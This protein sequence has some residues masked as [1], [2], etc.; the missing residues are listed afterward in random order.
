MI[1]IAD[2]GS[3]KTSWKLLTGGETQSFF[4]QGINPYFQR[5]DEI[6]ESFQKEV[7][8]LAVY[9]NS[10]QQF[11]FYG[12]GCGNEN[13]R[14]ILKKI[15]AEYFPNADVEINTDLLGAARGACRQSEAIAGILGTGSNSCVYNGSNVVYSLPSLGYI[16]GDEGS[17][18]FLG[19]KLIQAYLSKELTQENEAKFN[20]KYQLTKESILESVYKKSFP[21]RYL[22]SFAK[23]L[24][25]ELPNEQIYNMV[26]L[27]FQDFFDKMILKYPE[28]TT[29][30]VCLVG[31]IAWHFKTPLLEVARTNDVNIRTIIKDPIDGLVDFHTA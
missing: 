4:S 11:F 19:K 16:L 14:Q 13:N 17:G 20:S 26:S 30:P 25:E 12:T 1:L 29:L 9:Y 3:T 27:G 31:S 28:Q 22:A 24:Y 10:V 21:N 2:S 7:A 5:I 8:G 23:F 15:F 18:A 6:R